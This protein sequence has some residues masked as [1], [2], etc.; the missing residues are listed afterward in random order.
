MA[1]P[2]IVNTTSILGETFTGTATTSLADVVTCASNRVY[3]V[4]AMYI[5]NISASTAGTVDVGVVKSGGSIKYIAFGITVA[6]GTSLDLISK[7]IYLEEGDKIQ[8]KASNAST[9]DYVLSLEDIA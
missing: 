7:A 1:A 6:A 8:I 4:N 2:N 3:K 9:Y 5:A